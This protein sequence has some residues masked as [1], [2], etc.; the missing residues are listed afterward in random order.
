MHWPLCPNPEPGEPTPHHLQVPTRAVDWVWADPAHTLFLLP[1][2]ETDHWQSTSTFHNPRFL[3]WSFP[4][5][6]AYGR[7]KGSV[8][9]CPFMATPALERLWQMHECFQWLGVYL[10]RLQASTSVHIRDPTCAQA[11]RQVRWVITQFSCVRNHLHFQ[12]PSVRGAK[13]RV[14]HI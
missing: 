10:S 13:L 4:Q 5:S 3:P 11:S 1:R 7:W 14:L 12:P 2:E 8:I 9:C 6:P